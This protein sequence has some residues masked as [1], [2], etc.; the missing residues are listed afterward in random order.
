MNTKLKTMK[1][2][3]TEKEYNKLQRVK[4]ELQNILNDKTYSFVDEGYFMMS[5]H[6]YSKND[7]IKFITEKY[8]KIEAELETIKAKW[9]YKLFN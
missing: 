3:I 6:Y 5:Y 4:T 7:A 2:I 9:Y 8:K 1:V